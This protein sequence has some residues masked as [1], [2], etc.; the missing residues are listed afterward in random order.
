ME[1]L[2]GISAVN[3]P[4]VALLKPPEPPCL[5]VFGLYSG[6]ALLTDMRVRYT[7]GGAPDTTGGWLA[8]LVSGGC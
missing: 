3:L 7:F 1:P 4:A 8:L 2:A 6:V 5:I